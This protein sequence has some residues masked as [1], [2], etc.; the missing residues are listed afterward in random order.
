MNLEETDDNY[1]WMNDIDLNTS[2][3]NDNVNPTKKQ[4]LESGKN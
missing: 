3:N 2:N 1:S 4:K